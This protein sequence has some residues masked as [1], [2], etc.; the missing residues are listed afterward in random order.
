MEVLLVQWDI[1]G[2]TGSRQKLMEV[3]VVQWDIKGY[4]R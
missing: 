2:Y 1:K 3:L 4:T